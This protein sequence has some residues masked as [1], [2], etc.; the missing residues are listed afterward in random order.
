[1][2]AHPV[3]FGVIPA[4]A[5]SQ[6]LPGKNGRMLG[7]KPL[8]SWTVE[9]AAA[10]KA[11]THAWVSTDDEALAAIAR[12][13]GGQ[14]PFLRPS[15][16]A[17]ETASIFDVLKHAVAEYQRREGRAVDIVVLLQPTSPLRGPEPI[18]A[19]V[20]LVRGGADSAQT[21]ALDQSHPRIRFTIEAGRLKPLFADADRHSRRQ[22]GE[23][24]Y[25]PNG[26]VYAARTDVLL[27]SGTL[28]GA[29]HRAIVMDF[30]SSVD[31]D[32]IWDFKLAEFILAERAGGPR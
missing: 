12:A 18:D 13:H 8:L 29:D 3:V 23:A 20:A 5:G 19:V 26:A 22:D 27:E 2:K 11:L 28:H 15:E 1:M 10:S 17:T 16:L 31:I 30:E 24:I 14:A 9:A 4:R 21:V 32:T 25:R 6:G 7:G